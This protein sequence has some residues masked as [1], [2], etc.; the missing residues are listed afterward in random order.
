ALPM[1]PQTSLILTV[2]HAT[3]DG[4]AGGNDLGSHG[5]R[6]INMLD[7]DSAVTLLDFDPNIL[8]VEQ[9]TTALAG[10]TTSIFTINRDYG[11]FDRVEAPKAR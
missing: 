9:L 3:I 4:L 5:R 10:C 7:P 2:Y 11:M 8:S 1:S 6:Y